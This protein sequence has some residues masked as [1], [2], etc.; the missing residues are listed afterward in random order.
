[1]NRRRNTAIIIFLVTSIPVT[2][3]SRIIAYYMLDNNPGFSADS[4]A[5]YNI[6]AVAIGLIVPIV[7]YGFL[8]EFIRGY[9][10]LTF[11]VAAI[12]FSYVVRLIF[13]ISIAIDDTYYSVII[14]G[15]VAI[16]TV[17]LLIIISFI[18]LLDNQLEK[19]MRI[20]IFIIG[21]NHALFGMG[22]FSGLLNSVLDR[23]ADMDTITRAFSLMNIFN[24]GK[25]ILFLALSVYILY[26]AL[27][28]TDRTNEEVLIERSEY[29]K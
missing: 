11:F 28:E 26:I 7:F 10:S 4:I 8:W 13:L 1:M 2:V 15:G 16:I 20:P 5:L 14:S 9:K 27:S 6:I 24:V 22:I 18:V 29:F 19:N 12:A 21:F 17:I 25:Y 3:L 23:L